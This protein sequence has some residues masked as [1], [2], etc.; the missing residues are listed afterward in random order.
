MRALGV[1]SRRGVRGDHARGGDGGAVR[2][3]ARAARA[4]G[5][6]AA[7]H[8]DRAGER[9]RRA[10]RGRSSAAAM[11]RSWWRVPRAALALAGAR[12]ALPPCPEVWAVGPG[13]GARAR[14]AG[15]AARRAAGSSR[16]AS[17]ARALRRR[18]RARGPARAGAARRGRPRRGDR[19]AA[20]RRRDGR[21]DRRVPHGAGAADDPAPRARPR[22]AARAARSRCARCSRRR[23]S[24]RSTRSCGDPLGITARFAAIG[25]TTAAALREARAPAVAVADAPDTGRLGQGRVAAVY[26][27]ALMNYPDYRPRRMRRTEG[28]RRLVRETR[29]SVDDLVYPLFV[30]AGLGRREADRVDARAV[31]PLGRQ[32]HR[33]RRARRTTSASRPCSCSASPSTRTRSAARRGRTPASSRRRSARSRSSCPDLIVMV[34]A[35]FCEYT[36][37]G[38]CGVLHDGELDN[39]ASLENLAR[40]VVSLRARPASTSSRRAAC[41]TASSAR[42]ARALDEEQLRSGRDHGVLGEVRVGLLRAVPRGG[43]LGAA[44][45]AIAAATRWIRRTSPRRCARPRWTSPRAPTS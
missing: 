7:G 39:D 15:I 42:A 4:R 43:R 37:H 35:C 24:P 12:A 30:R 17:L 20:R 14:A 3:R 19:D 27:L 5:R 31:Q 18:A 8:P 2:G 29:L 13:D 33:R 38:H 1:Q 9:S 45:T 32:G 36:D 26:P 16:R 21:C 44:G 34:D 40:T 25:E 6:R 28:L 23:R 41:S 11:R 10:G 22:V